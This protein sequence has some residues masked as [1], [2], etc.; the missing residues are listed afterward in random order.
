MRHGNTFEKGETPIQVGARTDLPLTSFGRGQAEEM[1]LYL[2]AQGISPKMIYAGIL[3]RQAESAEIIGKKLGGPWLFE[4][5][6]TEIDYG[7]WEGLRSEEIGLRWGKEQA[8]W[9]LGKWP[10]HI[11]QGNEAHYREKLEHF[12]KSLKEG[13]ILAVTSNGI[14]RL[15]RNE[16]VQT[17]H[18]C[19]LHLKKNG[20]EIVQWNVKPNLGDR[21]SQFSFA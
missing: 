7:L 10:Q 5:A 4:S 13:P 16:K 12:L 19:E 3:K 20:W 6:L 21:L 18:F 1:A 9:A 17:G 11:F 15:L 14:L 8:E 2:A